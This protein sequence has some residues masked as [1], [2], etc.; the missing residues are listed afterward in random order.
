LH[1]ADPLS[2]IQKADNG[3]TVGVE[4]GE[5]FNL[6]EFVPQTNNFEF[7]ACG[8]DADH[9]AT[10]ASDY[11]ST[12]VV[13]TESAADHLVDTS[14]EEDGYCVVKN[15]EAAEAEAA[16]SKLPDRWAYQCV[17]K[18]SICPDFEHTSDPVMSNH[19]RK[20]HSCFVK[21]GGY[22]MSKEVAHRCCVCDAWIPW[23]PLILKGH[24]KINHQKVLS[25]YGSEFENEIAAQLEELKSE[26]DGSLY[27]AAKNSEEIEI[28]QKPVA[29]QQ[30]QKVS[31]RRRQEEEEAETRQPLPIAEPRMS[32]K[33][34]P[35]SSKWYN[36]CLYKCD[37][38]AVICTGLDSVKSHCESAHGQG[39]CYGVFREAFYQCKMCSEVVL[40]QKEEIEG[41]LRSRHKLTMDVYSEK[42][43]GGARS[44]KAVDKAAPA[45]TEIKKEL[46]LLKTA[47]SR[48]LLEKKEKPRV[49][50]P[51]WKDACQFKC[52]SCET[53]A[54]TRNKMRTH[55][56]KM[57]GDCTT[58]QYYVS[59]RV[60]HTCLA[61]KRPQ[62]CEAKLLNDHMHKSH[63][64]NLTSYEEKFY[65]P[66]LK[67]PS[68]PAKAALEK[69]GSGGQVVQS[70]SKAGSDDVEFKRKMQEKYTAILKKPLQPKRKLEFGGDQ[71]ELKE[72]VPTAL[73]APKKVEEKAASRKVPNADDQAR[74]LLKE[75]REKENQTPASPS[76][77]SG[78]PRG[79]TARKSFPTSSQKKFA[80]EVVFAKKSMTR[81]VETNTTDHD[82]RPLVRKDIP[83]VASPT[84]G[85][86]LPMVAR[87][88]L[89][90]VAKKPEVPVKEKPSSASQNNLPKVARKSLPLIACK[91]EFSAKETTSSA[92]KILSGIIEKKT[93]SV[94]N[95]VFKKS[96]VPTSAKVAE[97]KNPLDREGDW[98]DGCLFECSACPATAVRRDDMKKHCIGS[99]GNAGTINCYRM[100]VK[101]PYCCLICKRTL[102]RESKSLNDHMHKVHHINLVKYEARHR[103]T[104]HA[105]GGDVG[106]EA[107]KNDHLVKTD[108]KKT[109]S[110]KLKEPTKKKK[111]ASTNVVFDND[112]SPK[113]RLKLSVERCLLCDADVPV[114]DIADHS[115]ST[116]N[117][118][119]E[120]YRS[121]KAVLGQ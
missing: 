18:C 49:Y 23:S 88:S 113:K 48:K 84:V 19:C 32:V 85:D 121:L 26:N 70:K 63:K 75:V 42:M 106:G 45:V 68:S 62:M 79:P 24:M 38:C 21:A 98:K 58:K 64:F 37:V 39:N 15:A 61:C 83:L 29:I 12:V 103:H 112:A 1:E 108:K 78:M 95:N 81:I 47:T 6:K 111:D 72:H 59:K 120:R 66:S 109:E 25:A 60:D 54:D 77:I 99:H 7:V 69:K 5:Q 16:S 94:K 91:T 92:S 105:G 116:H 80:P 14:G 118:A 101:S 22:F 53:V 89:P 76:E 97:V 74:R 52:V 28:D 20:E 35:K 102:H 8:E 44:T 50:D 55:C 13:E 4:K 110:K 3:A 11:D 115:I 100:A 10:A 43:H 33:T 90:P 56:K 51:T 86:R 107:R 30:R 34:E 2:S 87:K 31:D 117:V 36:Q 93:S 41:H 104:I 71:K 96:L 65:K 40:C 9:A 73:A 27:N 67:V 17:F 119:P 46:N 114:Q 82:K 57:H